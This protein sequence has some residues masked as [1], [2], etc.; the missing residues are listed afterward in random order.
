MYDLILVRYGE[1][2]LKKKNYNMFLKKINQNIKNKCKHL[3]NLT[4]FNTAYRF[5]IYLNGEDYNE[6]V[7]I[8]DTVVGLYSYSLCKKVKPEYDDIALNA[9]TL[10]EQENVKSNSTFKVETN[11]GDKDFP[12]TSIQISQEVAKRVLA[13]NKQLQV[14]VHNPEVTLSIDLR[15]EGTYIFLNSRRGLGGY[16]SGTAGNGLLMMSGGIDSPVAGF[17]TIKKAVNLT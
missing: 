15:S 5:Y 17:L 14:D 16:P 11:R 7:K 4:F 1:M 3:N 10:L 2:T 6:V 12:A 13:Q 8:L 9:L